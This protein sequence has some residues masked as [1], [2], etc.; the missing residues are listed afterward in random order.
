[1]AKNNQ[2]AGASNTRKPDSNTRTLS[3]V[4]VALLFVLF[5]LVGI[6]AI[7]TGVGWVLIQVVQGLAWA[8][9]DLSS[10][11]GAIGWI[12]SVP[13]A[14]FAIHQAV[15]RSEPSGQAVA[16]T[17][18]PVPAWMRG[19]T[20]AGSAV[21]IMSGN[22]SMNIA[23]GRIES[24]YQ[25]RQQEGVD[26]YK[27]H[28]LARLV[29]QCVRL[30]IL[31]HAN[32]LPEGAERVALESIA[33]IAPEKW[34]EM[35]D[36]A[37]GKQADPRVL[38]L[39]DAK[40]TEFI[41]EP[42]AQALHCAEWES[43]LRE[44]RRAAKAD[45]VTD[46]T[47]TAAAA[48]IAK[49]FG[50]T[51]RE[52]LK[53]DFEKGGKAWAAMQLD[54][55]QQLL[56][57]TPVSMATDNEQ[58]N[59]ALAEVKRM[60][61]DDA[62][63]LPALHR[64]ILD[65]RQ[66]DDEYARDVAKRF[67][68]FWGLLA[69]L[70]EDVAS[71][72]D[73]A[74]TILSNQAIEAKIKIIEDD[75]SKTNDQKWQECDLLLKQI[76]ANAEPYGPREPISPDG[77]AAVLEVYKDAP[78]LRRFGALNRM[79]LDTEADALAK[80]IESDIAGRSAA[81]MYKFFVFRGDRFWIANDFHNA[82]TFYAQAMA[83]RVDE[84]AVVDRAARS[85]T[86]APGTT[87]YTQDL[88]L[89]LSWVELCLASLAEQPSASVIDIARLNATLAITLC[90]QGKSNESIAPARKALE[91]LAREE[92][93]PADRNYQILN[94]A[95]ES[96]L[97]AGALRESAVAADRAVAAAE[98]F[99][100]P[101]SGAAALTYA[102][103][104]RIRQSLGRLKEA[105]ED[106]A[107]AIEWEEKRDPRNEHN[108]ASYYASRA[109]IQ[110]DLGH[111]K[112]AEEDITLAINWKERQYPP[113]ERALAIFHASRADIRLY[114]GRPEEAEEDIEWSITW[115][116]QQSPRNGRALSS[117]YAS[118][119]DI[120]LYLGRPKEAEEDITKAISWEERKSPRDERSLAVYHTRRARVW[121]T[122][123]RP[124]EAEEDIEWSIR[125]QE[126]QSPRDERSL[127]IDYASR[128]NIRMDLG[129]LK[130]AE[131]DIERSIGWEEK[132]SP[133]NE[134]SL[135]ICHAQRARIRQKLGRLKEAE[136]DIEWSIR[137]Q[138]RQ[139][140]CN[141]RSLANWYATRAII[142]RDLKHFAVA[143]ADID[144]ALKWW[145]AN[146]PHDERTLGSWREIK[147][148]IDAAERR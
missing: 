14:A 18:H 58:I 7:L 60:L 23:A 64:T 105:E 90:Q 6:V 145:L 103:R 62:K 66:A 1:M 48:T 133:R 67:D 127:A 47:L 29:G 26:I 100:G 95:V 86:L 142:R 8:L 106:I 75:P 35:T 93:A 77:Q 116:E 78:K 92:E 15:S 81:D 49:V 52:T 88:Q 63:G 4:L 102:S 53:A 22:L 30:A 72:K 40:L 36:S 74:G 84:P 56:N 130:E 97:D 59:A 123:G 140:P 114:L 50:I 96:L 71:V 25:S 38:A 34:G 138:E 113:E 117:Y 110:L 54:I 146:L 104:A 147:A 57:Q 20:C 143:R 46:P 85:A 132:Q 5:F 82:A 136:E 39:A 73:R 32:T 9:A 126:K 61:A 134:G 41:Q 112:E 28:D 83:L 120:R 91:L 101:T 24:H 79:G 31:R 121:V 42:K 135:A 94:D 141:E 119:A 108:L 107:R 99:A 2:S 125:W 76:I 148:S 131:E 128:A 55:A 139:S 37:D 43:M 3:E 118:R 45:A 111:L 89:A 33:E 19:L 137:W 12:I 65:T 16:T 51:L 10:Y 21:V 122:L 109:R 87:S 68:Q 115:E 17:V 27:N 13:L 98:A 69:K 80:E 129:R 144:A 124:K 11:L 44:W 70:Q